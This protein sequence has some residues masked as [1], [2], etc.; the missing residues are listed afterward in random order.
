MAAFST[1]PAAPIAAPRRPTGGFMGAKAAIRVLTAATMALLTGCA[2]SQTMLAKKDLIVQAKTSTAVFVEPVA[3][4]KRSIY[5]EVKSGVEAFDRRAFKE[6]VAE[7]FA[8]SD[9]GYRV[10]D[11]PDAAQFLMV[12]YVL[13]LE[14]TNPTAAEKALEQG[15]K[16]QAVLAGARTGAGAGR[17]PP[18]AAPRG[19]PGG[20]A[21]QSLT[22][23][24]L[25]GLAGG[26]T[27]HV[28]S[29][30]VKDVTYMLV[31]DVQ[32]RERAADGV[33][34]RRDTDITAH[35]SDNGTT[36]QTASETLRHKEYRTRI[37]TTANKANLHLADAQPEMFRKTAF[38]MSG[39]F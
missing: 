28:T 19:P 27:E 1:T 12:A 29:Y 16:G 5:L 33:A 13:D 8:A 39:L 21:G 30:L 23:T 6:F 26:V 38:A 35:V 2:A 31:C 4:A 34:V 25:G 11:D 20:G 36:R 7:Q 24:A 17:A 15:Y 3:K 14:E 37:V 9:N 18:T 22:S 10:V 32:I